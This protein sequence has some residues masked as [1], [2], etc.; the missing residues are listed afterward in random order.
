M[1]ESVIG[2]GWVTWQPYGV[3]ETSFYAGGAPPKYI[4]PS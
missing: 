2:S 3:G 4:L 1:G